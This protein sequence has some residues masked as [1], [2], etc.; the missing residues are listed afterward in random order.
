LTWISA[1]LLISERTVF[2]HRQ[3]RIE[4]PGNGNPTEPATR[5]TT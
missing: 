4:I 1:N 5:F 3:I 2:G